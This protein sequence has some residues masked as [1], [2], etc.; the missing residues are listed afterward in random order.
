M[1]V[2]IGVVFESANNLVHEAVDDSERGTPPRYFIKCM[3]RSVPGR[4]AERVDTPISCLACIGD[5]LSIGVRG[6]WIHKVYEAEVR[7]KWNER[8]RL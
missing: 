1:S 8:N 7:A 5:T 3:S 4:Y 2:V 6:A